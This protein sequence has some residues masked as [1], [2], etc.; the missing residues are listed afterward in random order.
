M[1]S[2]HQPLNFIEDGDGIKGTQLGFQPVSFQPHAVAVGFARLRA[3]RLP[4]IR[5]HPAAERDKLADIEPHSLRDANYDFEVGFGAG[6][7]ARF[8]QKLEITAGVRKGARLLDR[9]STRLNSSHT[10]I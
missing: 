1:V 5:P 9:K 4:H 6:Y 10:V 2:R 8:P 7:F 3:P